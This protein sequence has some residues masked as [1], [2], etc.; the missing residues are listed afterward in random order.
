[1]ITRRLARPLGAFTSSSWICP[2]CTRA[3]L[4]QQRIA[5]QRRRRH[6]VPKLQEYD[7]TFRDEGVPG[8]F[9]PTGFEIGWKQ[10]QG[11][12]VKKLN[13]LTAGE[14]FENDN[15]KQLVT[16]FARDP[17][18]ASLFNHASMA[19]N[20]HFFFSGLSTSPV[21]LDDLPQLRD[22]LEDTFGSIDTLRTTMLDTAAAMFGPGFVWLVW[23]RKQ[24][25]IKRGE[26]RILTTYLAGTPYPEAGFR[27]QG[28]DTNVSNA[29][30]YEE[31]MAGEPANTVGYMGPASKSGRENASIPPGGTS[32]MPVLCVNT[33]EHVYIY[34]FGLPG[35]LNYLET[36]WDAI[37]WKV[38]EQ[39]TPQEAFRD[40]EGAPSRY[41]SGPRS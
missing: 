24:G 1:M 33:W 40:F 39:K 10:Y 3:S 11:M 2:S 37:D 5:E 38:V 35:K 20:N 6:D 36:W 18:A 29:Q 9:S 4:L 21:N 30:K 19:H 15:P 12:I 23:A 13:Q 28:I 27:H 32:L 31:Y 7:Q 16:Q 17:S 26:W 22:N 41:G 8:L 34:D 14:P 25:S